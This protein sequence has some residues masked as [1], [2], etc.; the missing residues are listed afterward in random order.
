MKVFAL[1]KFVKGWIVGN[2]EPSL[3]K[4]QYVE[5]SVK[6]FQAGEKEPSHKQVIATELTVIIEGKIVMNGKL[7]ETGSIIEIE[8]GEYADFESV[9]D[10][11]LV[12][13]KYPSI[14]EDKVIE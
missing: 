10:S 14:P 7:F 9:T 8:P 2:F 5:V 3:F 12:C 13:V 6:Y 11:K 1:E 4:N